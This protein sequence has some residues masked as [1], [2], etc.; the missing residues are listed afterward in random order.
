M[1]KLLGWHSGADGPSV[2]MPV[3]VVPLWEGIEPPSNGRVVEAEFRWDDKAAACD[4]DRACDASDHA[5]G[6]LFSF[7]SSAAYVHDGGQQIA[8]FES[9]DPTQQLILELWA[10]DEEEADDAL[11]QRALQD[12]PSGDSSEWKTLGEM[13]CISGEV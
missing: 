10:Y 9:E 13:N 5:C 8:I 3:E 2:V 1:A 12:M 6:E 7:G 11:L 4:Y